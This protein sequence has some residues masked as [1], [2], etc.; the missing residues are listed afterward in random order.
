MSFIPKMTPLYQV[1]GVTPGGNGSAADGAAC[2]RAPTRRAGHTRPRQM[3]Y[4]CRLLL[5]CPSIVPP[6]TR[7]DEARGKTKRWG[8]VNTLL[9]RHAAR[10]ATQEPPHH[11]HKLKRLNK[12][13]TPSCYALFVCLGFSAT[14]SVP[15]GARNSKTEGDPFRPRRSSILALKHKQ[16]ASPRGGLRI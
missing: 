5:R 9:T 1:K 2:R 11:T 3:R 10:I 7:T 4:R 14:L 13:F 6:P 16:S 12:L 8:G 15:T